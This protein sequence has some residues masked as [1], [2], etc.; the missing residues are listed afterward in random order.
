MAE[1]WSDYRSWYDE[2]PQPPKEIKEPS[3]DYDRMSDIEE[4]T[5]YEFDNTTKI[6]ALVGE[7]GTEAQKTAITINDTLS[8]VGDGI[9]SMSQL[10]K[11]MPLILVG[12]FFLYANKKGAI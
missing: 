2:E 12:G 8:N 11:Y 10:I 6:S 7:V 4:F 3:F 1:T 9:T 5:N